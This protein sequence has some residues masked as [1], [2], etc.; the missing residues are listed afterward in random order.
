[1]PVY[2][3]SEDIL[4]FPPATNANE[5]G[6]LAFGGKLS[7]DWLLAAYSKGLFPWYSE[8]DP[9]L[10]WSPDPRCVLIPA[11]VKIQKSMRSML[12]NKAYQ[13]KF[14]TAFEQ[15]IE[16]C[17]TIPRLD[18]PGTWLTAEMKQAYIRLHKIGMAHS[19]EVW[20]ENKLVGGL[21]GVSIGGV[22]FGESMFSKL[23][24]TSKLALICL[25]QWLD[26]RD[27]LMVD[28]Q[29]YSEHLARMGGI[30]VDR[31]HFLEAL[32]ECMAKPTLKG[33]WRV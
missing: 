15:V 27:F 17:A 1:M 2:R 6:L 4:A 8:G 16:A 29:I 11:E 13:F 12:N 33:F 22:F 28:C 21:Y 18:Q 26:E 24:N 14:D 23:P 5:D 10:W 31:T 30:E 25:C 3:L 19:A 7:E 9:I 32:D 20:K